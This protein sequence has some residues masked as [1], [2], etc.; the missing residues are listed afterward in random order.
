MELVVLVHLDHVNPTVD[1]NFVPAEQLVAPWRYGARSA[2]DFDRQLDAVVGG[3][4]KPF[5]P[6]VGFAEQ[7]EFGLRAF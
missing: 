3:V 7:D 2:A 1:P 4:I 6:P 5:V